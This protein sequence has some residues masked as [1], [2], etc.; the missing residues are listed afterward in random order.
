[1]EGFDQLGNKISRLS[2]GIEAGV[3]Q[4]ETVGIFGAFTIACKK[5]Y[6][7]SMLI[8][9][10]LGKMIT[11]R[12]HLDDI[13][14]PVKIAEYATKASQQGMYH[15]FYLIAVISINLG[16]VN[17]LPIPLLDGGHLMYYFIEWILRRPVPE[18]IQRI[19]FQIGTVIL[20]LLMGIAL[21]NDFK[22]LLS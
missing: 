22:S 9:E 2:I 1:M 13:G 18:K 14:G 6:V 15:L 11:Q 12:S 3:V 16:L 7:L 10:A 17:L 4:H 8:L 5:A 19:G 21:W 20:F